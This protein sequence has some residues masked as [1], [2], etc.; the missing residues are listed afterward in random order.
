M[1]KPENPLSPCS[2]PPAPCVLNDKSFT[3]HD[4]TPVRVAGHLA[5]SD[6][7]IHFWQ[8]DSNCKQPIK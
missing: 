2:L 4:M 3:G 8:K 1:Q 7:S 5:H 6:G